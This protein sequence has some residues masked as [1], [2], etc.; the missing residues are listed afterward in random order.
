M[1][2]RLMVPLAAA[3]AVALAMPASAQDYGGP[4]DADLAVQ[5][6]QPITGPNGVFTVSGSRAAEDLQLSTG[7]MFNLQNRPLV[8]EDD[9]V[10]TP[11]VENQF[12]ADLLFGIGLGGWLELGAG[13]SGLRA[14]RGRGQRPGR[15]WGNH[16][17]PAS[18]QQV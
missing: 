13:P 1:F 11:I 4:A 7:V 2:R 3:A 6:F 5:K 12:T 17:R 9:G 14:Q 18:A 10:I 8:L 16:R 15:G